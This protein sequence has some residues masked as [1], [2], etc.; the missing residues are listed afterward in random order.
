[1]G[2]DADRYARAGAAASA[3]E[4]LAGGGR[5]RR[6]TDRGGHP[7]VPCAGTGT[8]RSIEPLSGAVR[9]G[10]CACCAGDRDHADAPCPAA[11][12]AHRPSNG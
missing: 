10:V 2:R 5:G 6:G 8:V 3:R 4:Y 11:R 12:P 1:M 9:H 7:C